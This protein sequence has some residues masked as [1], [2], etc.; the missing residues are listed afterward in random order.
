VS[1]WGAGATDAGAGVVTGGLLGAG[2][3]FPA[4][5]TAAGTGVFSATNPLSWDDA[6]ASEDAAGTA[7]DAFCASAKK[8]KPPA[9]KTRSKVFIYSA[10]PSPGNN[11]A[12]RTLR[13]FL[14][15]SASFL[16][17]LWPV[18]SK[19]VRG[20]CGSGDDQE[21]DQTGVQV[22]PTGRWVAKSTPPTACSAVVSIQAIA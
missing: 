15:I 16:G 12:M 6:S 4:G 5:I 10:R 3:T 13:L 19:T 2:A 21:P 11:S 20:R 8:A 9:A 17:E 7:F 14:R 18:L 22:F 1:G